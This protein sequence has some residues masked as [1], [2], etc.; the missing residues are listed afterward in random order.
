MRKGQDNTWRPNKPSPPLFV[1]FVLFVVVLVGVAVGM[2]CPG[3]QWRRDRKGEKRSKNACL[4]VITGGCFPSRRFLRF[5][6]LSYL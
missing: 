2:I 5:S 4:D 1:L 3:P 6:R